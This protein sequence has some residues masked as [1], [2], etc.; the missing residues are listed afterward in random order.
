MKELL[1]IEIDKFDL[2]AQ[3]QFD[4]PQNDIGGVWEYDYENWKE[5]YKSFEDFILT[6]DPQKLT[7]NQ[8][9]RQ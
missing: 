4:I 6:T 7:D 8:K 9:E 5:I 1:F 2:W 3:T